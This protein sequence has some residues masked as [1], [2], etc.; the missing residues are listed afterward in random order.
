[1]E[2]SWDESSSGG[3]G[4]ARADWP[5]NAD[6]DRSAEEE[7]PSKIFPHHHHHHLKCVNKLVNRSLLLIGSSAAINLRKS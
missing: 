1:M 6:Q 4:S 5:P 7:E 3:A 2:E